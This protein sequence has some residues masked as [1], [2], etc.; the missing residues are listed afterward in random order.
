MPSGGR[1]RD[2]GGAGAQRLDIS[3]ESPERAGGASFVAE[4]PVELQASLV[5]GGG[6]ARVSVLRRGVTQVDQR[7]R[8]TR[9]VSETLVE[10]QAPF[11]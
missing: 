1:R 4:L 2:I 11:V 5:E 10:L 6:A 8:P 9:P 7:E 3:C